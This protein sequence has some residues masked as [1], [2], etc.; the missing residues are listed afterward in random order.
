MAQKTQK[1]PKDKEPGHI[2]RQ[3]SEMWISSKRTQ[4]AQNSLNADKEK[5][6]PKVAD[7]SELT[8]GQIQRVE[9]S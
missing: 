2:V 8:Q 7:W 5:A 4:A 6:W 9:E 3:S 1:G